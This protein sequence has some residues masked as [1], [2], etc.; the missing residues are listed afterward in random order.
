MSLLS[1]LS[2]SWTTLGV[3]CAEPETH[4]SAGEDE[5]FEKYLAICEYEGEDSSLISFP[6]GAS[7]T[8]IDK[9]EDGMWS[10]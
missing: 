1:E 3:W 10:S 5:A 4:T 2:S 9:D 8:V 6:E 7:I